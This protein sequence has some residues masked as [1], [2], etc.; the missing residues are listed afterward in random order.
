[1]ENMKKF[2]LFLFLLV[3]NLGYSSTYIDGIKQQPEITGA[4]TSVNGE[5]GDVILTQDNIVDGSVYVKTNNNFTDTEKTRLSLLT[6]TALAFLDEVNTF[7]DA[8]VIKKTSASALDVQNDDG[9][10]MFITDTTTGNS[11]VMTD[12][13]RRQL[14]IHNRATDTGTYLQ[15]TNDT[16]GDSDG[17][18]GLVIG[19][20][21]AEKANFLNYSN[22]DMGFFTNGV[23]RVRISNAGNV[24]IGGNFTA[25]SPLSVVSANPVT[26]DTTT[27]IVSRFFSYTTPTFGAGIGGTIT[28]GGMVNAGTSVR[29]YASISGVKENGTSNN[30]AGNLVL[31]VRKADETLSEAM[32]ITSA[33]NVTMSGYLTSKKSGVFGY[34][35]TP[36]ATTITT[37]GTYYP[38][39][40]DFVN[41]LEDFGSATVNTPGIKYNGTLTRYFEIDLHAQVEANSLNTDV[42]IA[43]HKNGELCPCS[44]ITTVC[45]DANSPYAISSTVVIEL[46]QNDEVQLMTTSDGNG[47]QLTFIN[48][49]TTIRPFF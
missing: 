9:V 16:T 29:D 40:G 44:V 41:I 10:T 19:I 37:A 38:I 17:A 31:K 43:I 12:T 36:S 49:Q 28:L 13:P 1:V 48:L 11:G 30:A 2:I 34:I 7:T 4:V 24:N 33:G 21:A 39:E 45:R 23:E 46:A 47:D 15:L 22:T 18:L 26:I 8:Q 42:S 3:F 14:H 20:S 27:D 5:T 32:R 35:S 25:S 6:P